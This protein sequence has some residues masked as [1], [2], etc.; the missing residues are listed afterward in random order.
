MQSTAV[1]AAIVF[2]VAVRAQWR[3]LVECPCFLWESVYCMAV[4]TEVSR[5]QTAVNTRPVERCLVAKGEDAHGDEWR[6]C[7]GG[8]S[9]RRGWPR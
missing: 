5:L 7:G 1:V 4:V 3:H 9:S 6:S 2:A 8:T